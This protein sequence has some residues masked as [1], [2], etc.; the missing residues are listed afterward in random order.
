MGELLAWRQ[1]LP[2]LRCSWL[3]PLLRDPVLRPQIRRVP[4]RALFVI[5]TADSH[6][7]P[8]YLAEIT[9]E[10]TAG[11]SLV[12]PGA[13]HSLELRGDVAGS[14]RELQKIVAEIDRFLGN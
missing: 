12:I 6:C 14:P 11:E 3:T 10:A 1:D 9:L 8:E 5:G 13:D 2:G 7:R 4:H